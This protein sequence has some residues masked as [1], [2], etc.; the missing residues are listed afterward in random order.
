MTRNIFLL[1]HF[2]TEN[3]LYG[4]INGRSLEIKIIDT[5]PK[6]ISNLYNFDFIFCSTALRCKQTLSIYSP[7]IICENIIYTEN[8][9]ERNM[10]IMEGKKRKEMIKD[11]PRLFKNKYFDVFKTPPSGESFSDL[12]KRCKI[13]LASISDLEGN[14]LICSHNQCLKMLYFL[15]K[16]QKINNEVW[17]ELSFPFGEIFAI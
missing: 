13:F 12:E 5:K 16:K 3:N 10:G 11:F 7:Y 8:L 17:N 2:K 4:L 6:N 14:I 9:L 1:R 15:I